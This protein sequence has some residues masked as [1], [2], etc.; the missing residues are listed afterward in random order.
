MKTLIKITTVL[1]IGL[2]SLTAEAQQNPMFT[3]Y[4]Y[5]TLVVNPGYAGSREALTVTALNRAQWVDFD[6]APRTQTLTMHTPLRNEH[7]GVG[8]SLMNDKIG[9]SNNTAVN[10]HFAYRM[11]LT[12]K[13]KLA[14]GLTG[15]ADINQAKINNLN[16][17]QQGDPVFQNNLRNHATPNVGFGAYYSRERFYTGLS[18]PNLLQNSY[19]ETNTNGNTL[20]SKQQRHYFF[21]AGAVFNLSHDVAFKP[22]TLVKVTAAA[23]AQADFTAT[24]VLMR[25]LHVGAMIRTGD[26]YGALVGL[27]LTDQFYLGYSFD[28]SYGLN[29]FRYNQGSHEIVLRYDFIFAS[30]KQIHSPRHF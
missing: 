22:T 11:K 9:P 15:G 1:V 4:M 30:K 16:T 5:N 7:I 24:F 3:H 8:L 25:K 23:P 14:L 28:K 21:I 18:V 13:A 10:A 17:D 12:S 2:G 27:N 6:G 26:A 20:V 29:T 19:S